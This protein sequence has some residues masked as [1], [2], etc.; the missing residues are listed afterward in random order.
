[1]EDPTTFLAREQYASDA[2]TQ[3][4]A[5]SDAVD[6]SMKRRWSHART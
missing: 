3:A 5:A 1:M 4:G 2:A 6:G